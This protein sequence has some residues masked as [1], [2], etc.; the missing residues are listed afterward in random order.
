MTHGMTHRKTRARWMT[1]ALMATAATA[2]APPKAQRLEPLLPMDEKAPA[3][4]AA[5]LVGDL[6]GDDV[7]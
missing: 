6:R 1:L 7:G 3:F 5:Q 4:I 2:C